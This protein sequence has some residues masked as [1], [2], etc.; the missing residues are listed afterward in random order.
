MP[1][2]KEVPATHHMLLS[3]GLKRSYLNYCSIFLTNL[4]N[5]KAFF[6]T[7]FLAAVSIHT[8]LAQQ[9][10]P[11]HREDTTALMNEAETKLQK[12]SASVSSILSD[13]KYLLLHPKSSFREMIKKNASATILTITTNDEPGKK[14]KVIGAVKNKD[15]QPVA[16]ALVYLYQ[17]DYRGWYADDAP[18]VLMNEG[19]FRHARL[20]GYV[21][22]DKNGKFELHT[23]KPSGYPKSDLLA[24]IHVH[25]MAE[26]YSSFGTEFLFQDDERLKGEILNRAVVDGGIIAKPESSAVPFEQQFSYE[27]KLRRE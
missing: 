10:V 4:P 22:T 23:I 27:I 26:G 25:V 19:D 2:E 11:I 20:F 16:D 3:T 15:G 9:L 13:K 14:I 1:L 21:K 7:L 5:M 24:H 6:L 17:T 18:H 12:G 8:L